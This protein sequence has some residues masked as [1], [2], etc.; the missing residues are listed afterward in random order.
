MS[1]QT[2]L[3]DGTLT[4][5]TWTRALSD[6]T[7]LGQECADC[8]HVT[9][10]PKA[11]CVRCG[12]RDTKTVELPTTGTVYTVTTVHVAPVPFEDEGSYD[13]AL[14]NAGDARLMAHVEESV[15]IGDEVELDGAVEHKKGAGALFSPVDD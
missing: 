13:V 8:G 7:L 12:G 1:V 5:E 9:A 10:A 11:V 14:V 3:E 6:G 15:A 4:K 2:Y